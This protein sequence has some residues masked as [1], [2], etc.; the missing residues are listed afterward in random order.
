MAQVRAKV[1]VFIDNALRDAG[2][3]FE[4]NGPEN[5][6]LEMLTNPAPANRDTPEAIA[7]RPRPRG[8]PRKIV[9]R[10]SESA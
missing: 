10:D 5:K 3:V 2:D 4:Y 7:E 6:H 8:R 9:E 1:R